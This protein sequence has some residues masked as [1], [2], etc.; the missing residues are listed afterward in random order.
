MKRAAK[1]GRCKHCQGA[2]FHKCHRCGAWLCAHGMAP[3]GRLRKV[4]KQEGR[5]DLICWP[6]CRKTRSDIGTSR[7]QP[8][9]E[10]LEEESLMPC[11]NC[12]GE[13]ST[14]LCKEPRPIASPT[15]H[16]EITW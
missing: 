13:H 14:R 16:E 1:M 6:R 11:A 3:C 8:S 7:V 4:P 2:A 15:P 10:E 5:Y 9:R 12:A